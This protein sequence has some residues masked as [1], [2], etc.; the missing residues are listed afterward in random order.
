MNSFKNYYDVLGVDSTANDAAIK[1]A[2]RRLARRHHPDVAK[3]KR[4]IVAPSQLGSVEF[5]A[6][7]F[8]TCLVIILGHT[9]CGAVQAT[10]EEL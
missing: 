7:R 5:A 9:G 1:T 8:G 10:L 4:A 2:F 3:D 6:E